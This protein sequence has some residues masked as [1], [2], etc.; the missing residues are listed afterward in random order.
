MDKNPDTNIAIQIGTISTRK[1]IVCLCK[2]FLSLKKR[3][4]AA[5]SVQKQGTCSTPERTHS[6]E[7]RNIFV[8]NE[9]V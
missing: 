4:E 5:S 8:C 3:S 7:N 9:Y 2:D 6:L 1:A